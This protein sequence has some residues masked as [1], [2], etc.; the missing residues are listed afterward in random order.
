[1]SISLRGASTAATDTAQVILMDQT[2]T[3]LNHLF[4]LAQNFEANQKT[5]LAT[6]FVPSIFCVG[7]IFFRDF[8]IPSAILFY[9][10]SAIAGIGNALLPLLNHQKK[11][12]CL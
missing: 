10:I 5:G 2:L 3:K 12:N 7:G 9:N 8:G 1:M 4:E 6:T 11:L